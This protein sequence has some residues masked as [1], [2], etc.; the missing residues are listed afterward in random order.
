MTRDLLEEGDNGWLNEF[1][2]ESTEL[3]A[4]G[5]PGSYGSGDELTI[6][7]YGNGYYLSRQACAELSL[8]QRIRILDLR[9][10]VPLNIDKVVA[11]LGNSKHILI[12]DECRQR[13]S[14]SEELVTALHEN[15]D[16]LHID[17]ITAKDCFIPLGGAANTVLPQKADIIEYLKEQL[18]L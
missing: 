7:T 15:L 8:K 13:G 16:E 14:L 6:I 12:V 9:Y 18:S 4:F 5:E 1:P 3:P 11:A 2:P 17:R 10:L